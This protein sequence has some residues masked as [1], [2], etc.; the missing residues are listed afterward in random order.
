MEAI[1]VESRKEEQNKKEKQSWMLINCW[2]EHRNLS[3]ITYI[4]YNNVICI[5]R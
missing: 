5:G 3:R 1:W 2:E 4:L